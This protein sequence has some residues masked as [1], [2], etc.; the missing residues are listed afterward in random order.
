MRLRA[1]LSIVLV[2]GAAVSAQ[3]VTFDRLLHADREPQNWLTY[4]GDLAGRRYSLLTEIT[5][6]NV[7]NL[8]LQWVFQTRGPAEPTEKFEATPLVVDG[9]M[10][11]VLAPNHVVALDAATGRLF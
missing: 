1:V 5:P 2:A 10:Y 6:A 11:T 4:S 3:E 8:E 9:V 7:R